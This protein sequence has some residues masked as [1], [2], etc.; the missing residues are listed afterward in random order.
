[1]ERARRLIE[2]YTRMEGV[3]GV[4]LVGS[5][6]RPFRDPLSDYD[7]EVAME[8]EAFSRVPAD[9]KLTFVIDEGPPRRVDHEFYLRPWKELESLVRST[10]DL[11]HYP[12]QYAK[13]FHD[14]SGRLGRLVQTLA[15]LPDAVRAT[16][17]KVHYLEFRFGASRAGKCLDRCGTLNANLVLGESITAL[18]KLLFV[19]KR[20][21]PS[22]RHWSDEELKLVGVGPDL[23]ASIG[24]AL[25]SPEKARLQAL[26]K[27]VDRF[28]EEEGETFHKNAQKLMQWAYLTDAG[29]RAFRRWGAR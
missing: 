12:F 24:V 19:A 25:S 23:I 11:D 28:L 5:A 21:W 1:V 17:M 2:P 16:R 26:G 20:S 6:T 18:V 15:V 7:F 9:K 13:V 4:Y 3:I 8:D 22:T 27:E 29:K 10:L 14:P